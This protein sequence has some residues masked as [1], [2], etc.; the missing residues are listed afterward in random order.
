MDR[1]RIESLVNLLK[2]PVLPEGMRDPAHR[3]LTNKC[4]IYA[5]GA[6]KRQKREEAEYYLSLPTR[7]L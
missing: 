1:F 6:Q 4:R 2:S 3:E 5:M 7:V